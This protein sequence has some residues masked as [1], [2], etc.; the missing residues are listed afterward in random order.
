M[1][2]RSVIDE[3]AGQADDFLAGAANR[4]ERR[5]EDDANGG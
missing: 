4:N 3:I 2:L 1:D 5:A